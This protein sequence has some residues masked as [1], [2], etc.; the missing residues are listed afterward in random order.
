MDALDYGQFLWFTDP[1]GVTQKIIL[2]DRHPVK[3]ITRT[4]L[5]MKGAAVAS[6]MSQMSGEQYAAVV[7][8][9]SAMKEARM[10]DERRLKE[11]AERFRPVIV[12]PVAVGSILVWLFKK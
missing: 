6:R 8:E 10:K 2:S 11:I 5:D 4:V 1:E 9:A 7:R 12:V 3:P